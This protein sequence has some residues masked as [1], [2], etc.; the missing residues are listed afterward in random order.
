MCSIICLCAN[1][2]LLLHTLQMKHSTRKLSNSMII[3]L[4]G[5]P[6]GQHTWGA[7]F[8]LPLLFYTSA[9]IFDFVIL[10]VSIQQT[11]YSSRSFQY[12]FKNTRLCTNMQELCQITRF[13]CFCHKYL[14]RRSYP[15][16]RSSSS[17]KLP[18]PPHHLFIYRTHQLC[19][20]IQSKMGGLRRACSTSPTIFAYG[21]RNKAAKS[22]VKKTVFVFISLV[23]QKACNQ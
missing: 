20:A 3:S 17:I 18:T 10:L 11:T 14:F 12:F 4:S 2:G 13:E 16:I 1:N 8:I 21:A 22:A 19:F 5:L 6:F 15:Q 7:F 9:I 23:I